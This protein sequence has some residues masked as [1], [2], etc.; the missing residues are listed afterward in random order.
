MKHI[1]EDPIDE[2]Y[3]IRMELL[4]EFGGIRGYF[5]HLDEMR[6]KWEAMGFKYVAPKVP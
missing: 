1:E 4:E 5:K 2:V 3:R 6:P